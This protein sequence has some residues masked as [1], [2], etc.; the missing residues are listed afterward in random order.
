MNSSLN[1]IIQGE[2]ILQDNGISVKN[3]ENLAHITE[4]LDLMLTALQ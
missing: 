1:T 2:Y 3:T 4:D